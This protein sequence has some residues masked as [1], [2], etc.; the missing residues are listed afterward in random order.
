M[1]VD[2]ISELVDVG[3]RETVGESLVVGQ[4]GVDEVVDVPLFKK[5]RSDNE[6][7]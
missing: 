1:E 7:R 2:Q 5:S 4:L 6:F 3:R